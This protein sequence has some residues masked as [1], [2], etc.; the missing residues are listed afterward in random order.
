MWVAKELGELESGAELGRECRLPRM[1]YGIPA[2]V[3][4]LNAHPK[5][6]GLWLLWLEGQRPSLTWKSVADFL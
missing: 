4:T 2:G 1:G 3:L 5:F 6:L